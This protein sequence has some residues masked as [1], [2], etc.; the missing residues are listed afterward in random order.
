[1]SDITIRPLCWSNTQTTTKC[2][3]RKLPHNSN[4]IIALSRTQTKTGNTKQG[5]QSS[6]LLYDV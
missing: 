4:Q 2:S 5:K 3:A 1:M 6:A